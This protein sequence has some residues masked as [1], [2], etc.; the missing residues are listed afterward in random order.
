MVFT[1]LIGAIAAGNAAVVK[2]SEVAPHTA[3]LVESLIARYLDTSAI[4]VVQGAIPETTLLLQQRYDHI[5]YTGNTAVGKVI[6]QAAAQYL[7]PVTLE[8]GGK[9]PVIIDKDANINLAAHR[10]MW[11]KL[12]N[13]GQICVSPDYILVHRDVRE[14]FIVAAKAA[15]TEYL[16]ENPQAS[17]SYG[18]IVNRNHF[19]RV[20]GLLAGGGG[21]VVCGGKTDASDLFIEPTLIADPDPESPLMK[22]EIFGACGFCRTPPCWSSCVLASNRRAESVRARAKALHSRAC[23]VCVFLQARCFQLF[24]LVAWTKRSVG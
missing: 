18:R 10:I 19:E 22:T 13:A 4:K 17:A 14:K 7:T 1:P 15:V 24:Q 21:T 6:L 20:S 23:C 5:F 2:P 3:M 8:L 12:T 16:G 9:S 11:S